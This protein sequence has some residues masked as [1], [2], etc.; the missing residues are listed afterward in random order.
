M[1][2][3]TKIA[4]LDSNNNIVVIESTADGNALPVIAV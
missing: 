2:D 1:S 3:S 4:Y